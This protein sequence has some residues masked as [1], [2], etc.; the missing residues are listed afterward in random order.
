MAKIAVHMTGGIAVYKAVEVVRGLQKQGH[1][2]RVAMTKN[3]ARFV[4]PATLAALIKHPVLIDQWSATLNGQ[5]PH[6]ELAD[7]SDLALV[8]PATANI[9]AKMA[10][11]LADDAVSATL[12]A[13]SAPKMA[14]PA[15][16][17]HMW[18][19]PA[20]QRNIA[21]L[22][23]DGVIIMEPADG[24]LAEGY[25][26]K[27]RMPEPAEIVKQVQNC[28]TKQPLQSSAANG[29]LKGKTIVVTAGG[30]REALDPVR[31]LG[32]RSSGKMG[33]AIAQAAAASGAKVEL[34]VGSVSVELPQSPNIAITTALSTQA[35]ADAVS[36]KFAHADALIMAAAVADFR[37]AVLADQKIKKHGDG[38]L[39]LHLVPT[40]DILATMGAQ[41]K[42]G[43]AVIGFAAETNDLLQNANAKL[44]KKHADVIVANDVS[45]P[46]IGFGSDANAVTI[47]R[48]NQAPLKWPRQSKQKIAAK[49]VDLA[50]QLLKAGD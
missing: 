23:Q 30:T 32:N 6:I 1:E 5:V 35:M 17:V 39:T 44:A 13:T 4:G 27:G 8:V 16:N 31:Y 43:Q 25:A 3:A 38:T 50:N 49:I 18:N 36:Q 41:K 26:G 2:V 24:M 34:I 10:N 28:L 14:V 7:W 11:G 22:K 19:N 37:P 20:T 12:L 48:P 9:L 29:Q 46:G 42:P 45:K 47:L 40:E 15:M 33:I 21:Q